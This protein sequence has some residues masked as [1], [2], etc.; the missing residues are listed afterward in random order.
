MTLSHLRFTPHQHIQ[1]LQGKCR[2]MPK[3]NYEDTDPDERG[4]SNNR[5]GTCSLSLSHFSLFA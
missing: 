1:V 5:P 4:H 3:P 2:R